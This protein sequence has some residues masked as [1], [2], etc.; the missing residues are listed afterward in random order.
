[1][2]HV[3]AHS[4]RKQFMEGGTGGTM[5]VSSG[6]VFSELITTLQDISKEETSE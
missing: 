3:H 4:A 5:S 2:S 6:T 1:M